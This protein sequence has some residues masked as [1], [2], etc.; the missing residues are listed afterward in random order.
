MITLHIENTVRDFDAWKAT[1]DK[2][3]RVRRDRGVRRY[4]ITRST[5]D[6]G[7]VMVDLEFDS[8]TRAEEF[9][10]L[11]R[12]VRHTPQA[13]SQLLNP[14]DVPRVFEVMEEQRLS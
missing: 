4:R 5:E 12:T 11:L 2:F 3:D 6:P 8:A 7:Q 10:E 14:D 9:R 13:L 1:F